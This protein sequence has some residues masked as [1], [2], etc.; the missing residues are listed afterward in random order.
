MARLAALIPWGTLGPMT[1]CIT[2]ATAGI[3]LA[4]AE[5]LAAEGTDLVV[6]ARDHQRLAALA[7]RLASEHG[8]Q[9]EVLVADLATD[10]GCTAVMDRLAD[11]SRPIDVLVNN[12]GFGVNHAFVAGSL[13]DEERLLDVLVRATL[14]LSHA[15]LP[16]MVQRGRG[17][18][19]NVSSVAGWVPIGTYSAAKSWVTV[20]SEGLGAELSGSG[21]TATAVCPGFTH[22]EFHERADMDLS[23]IPEWAWL[24]ARRVARDGLRAARSGRSVSVPS[25]RYSALALVAQLTPRPLLRRMS[26]ALS[27]SGTSGR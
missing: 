12:A 15:V 7:D 23:G 14:R 2:G 27:T 21:V 25:K 11:D 24:D 3:G 5:E 26:T 20:F 1:A 9:V 4:F 19:I 6:V 22:T 8:I 10:A 16:G 17:T 13:A 18:V